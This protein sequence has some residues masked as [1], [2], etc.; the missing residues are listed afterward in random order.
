MWVRF[1]VCLFFCSELCI[2]E[3]WLVLHVQRPKIRSSNQGLLVVPRAQLKTKGDCAFEVVAPTLWNTL[4]ADTQSV[5]SVDA[6]KKQLKTG[7]CLASYCLGFVFCVFLRSVVAC[8]IV[9][10]IISHI[11]LSLT[12]LLLWST[13]WPYSVKGAILNKLYLLTNLPKLTHL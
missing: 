2:N 9:S 7:L 13:L 12:I 3:L 11:V 1:F 10:F 5:V 8:F 4:P 6:F